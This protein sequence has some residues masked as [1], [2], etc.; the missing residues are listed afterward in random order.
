MV[1]TCFDPQE[2]DVVITCHQTGEQAIV[3]WTNYNKAKQRYRELNG[4]SRAQ[5]EG[6]GGRVYS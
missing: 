6:G 5:F 1:I 2:G 4:K 3:T